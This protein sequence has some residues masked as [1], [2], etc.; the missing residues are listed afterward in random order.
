MSTLADAGR[1]MRRER[2]VILG[3]AAYMS[4]E[5]ARGKPVDRR[6]DIWAFGCVAVRDA[7]RAARLSRAQ[8]VAETLAA[9]LERD[10]DWKLLP[11]STPP[12]IRELLRHCLQRNLA[13]RV[14]NI[15]E[16]R[17]TLDQA[18]R[19]WS[20]WRIAAIAAAVVATLAVAAAVWWREPAQPADRF[21][22]VQLTQFSD[23][24]VQPALSPDGRMLAFIRGP[25]AFGG[26]V[27]C[28]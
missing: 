25:S 8:T 2:G 19:G 6:A 18:Q 3:T 20:P 9:I 10:P 22:W 26:P 21:E 23:S 14:Q 17:D 15:A 12:R 7:H 5:Q 28:M 27:R 24:V 1:A 13:L 16:A 11:S 4:P